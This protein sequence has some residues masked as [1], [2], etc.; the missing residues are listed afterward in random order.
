[1]NIEDNKAEL[2]A[3][4]IEAF[5]MAMD[6]AGIP[7]ADTSGKVFSMYGRALEMARIS[8]NLGFILIEPKRASR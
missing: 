8:L 4:D 5:H 2:L 1:M 7:R 3:E 6:K